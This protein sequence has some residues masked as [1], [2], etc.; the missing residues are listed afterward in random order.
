MISVFSD[1]LAEYL[2]ERG[3][4]PPHPRCARRDGGWH[5]KHFALFRRAARTTRPAKHFLKK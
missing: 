1:R 2:P 3:V 4:L 5:V